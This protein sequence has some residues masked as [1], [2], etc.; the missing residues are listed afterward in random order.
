MS[1]LTGHPPTPA[2]T[3]LRR[4][5]I[6]L[7]L[8]GV[9]AGVVASIKTLLA[10]PETSRR[11]VSKISILPDTPPPPP[12][13]REEPKKEPPKESPKQAQQEAP[14]QEAP[15]PPEQ[16]IK[17]EGAAGEGASPFQSGAVTQEYKSGTPTIGAS[18]PSG[19]GDRTQERFYA[20][21]VRQLLREQ[22]EKNLPADG[23]ELTSTFAIWVEADGRI[24][25]F[26]VVPSG[27]AKRDAEVGA[28]LDSTSRDLRLPPPG[29]L[30]QPMRF[31]LTLRA[32]A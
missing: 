14:K 21:N 15:R 11:Q 10:T 4:A 25:K 18:G 5:L 20:N 27:E 26:E 3:W 6:A 12:P 7:V 23:A 9:V 30:P 32:Q 29:A 8:I 13:P 17:M 22:I 2:S 28:A 19:S 1:T 31:R 16:A 24:R